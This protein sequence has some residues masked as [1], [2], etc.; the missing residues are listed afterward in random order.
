MDD[1]LQR[2][3]ALAWRTVPA[4]QAN[5]AILRAR[6]ATAAAASRGALDASDAP[7]PIHADPAQD[8]DDP[9]APMARAYELVLPPDATFESFSRAQ[10]PRLVYHLESI[11]AHPP[12]AGGVVVCLFAGQQLHFLQ[13]GELLAAVCAELAIS[14]AELVRRYGTGELRTAVRA[15]APLPL[16]GPAASSSR[17]LA[18]A[19]ASTP[20]P[21]STAAPATDARPLALP[22]PDV[23]R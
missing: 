8:L 11:G 3:V 20:A 7:G 17:A 15:A 2:M 6:R 19:A 9:D 22:P 12:R 10:L 14:S 1:A 13:A 21:A 4:T 16:P 5:E 18:P 23:K